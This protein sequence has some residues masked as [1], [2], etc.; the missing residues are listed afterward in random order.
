MDTKIFGII[1]YLNKTVC[2]KFINL[3]LFNEVIVK[4]LFINTYIRN[5]MMEGK[6]YLVPSAYYPTQLLKPQAWILVLQLLYVKR[7]LVD[8][9]SIFGLNILETFHGS[10]SSHLCIERT[11]SRVCSNFMQLAVKESSWVFKCE[12]RSIN[13]FKF[14]NNTVVL[15]SI[16]T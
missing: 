9:F 4:I 10:W 2:I 14:W 16:R 13:F 5:T 7:I 1:L 6:E 8:L 3:F 15:Y 12:V 11:C